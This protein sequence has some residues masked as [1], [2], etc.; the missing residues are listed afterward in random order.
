MES[1]PNVVSIPKMMPHPGLLRNIGIPS[2]EIQKLSD[3][4]CWGWRAIFRS[5]SFIIMIFHR[6][7][8]AEVA[9]TFPTVEK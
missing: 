3:Y 6:H 1:P 5:P 8:N 7:S 9:V 4:P 2:K